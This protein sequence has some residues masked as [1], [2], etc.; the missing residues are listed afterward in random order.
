MGK[1]NKKTIKKQRE[2][3]LMVRK[4]RGLIISWTD[5]DPLAEVSLKEDVD[6]EY[7][8][9]RHK[10][11]YV[12]QIGAD[13]LFDVLTLSEFKRQPMNWQID[14]SIDCKDSK[15]DFYPGP[16]AT[17][18]CNGCIWADLTE[19]TEETIEKL[20]SMSNPNHIERVRFVATLV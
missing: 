17:I 1:T 8:Y 20:F 6:F 18:S 19:A 11:P 13:T 3:K 5:R 2:I 12:N 4:M 16:E 15:G 9:V 10:N 14:L 7:E